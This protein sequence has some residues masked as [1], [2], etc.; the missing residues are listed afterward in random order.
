MRSP[1][2][3]FLAT[4]VT[5]RLIHVHVFPSLV[6]ASADESNTPPSEIREERSF[7]LKQI[8]RTTSIMML[9]IPS[10]TN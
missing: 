5:L 8:R 2:D 9:A 10:S 3:R 4:S 7:S 6:E 1:T